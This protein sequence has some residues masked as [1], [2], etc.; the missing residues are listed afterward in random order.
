L[1][2]REAPLDWASMLNSRAQIAAGTA[3]NVVAVA[4]LVVAEKI[5]AVLVSTVID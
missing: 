4:D 2:R 5:G 1:R 3:S